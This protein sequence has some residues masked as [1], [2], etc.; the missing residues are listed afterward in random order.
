[1]HLA[2]CALCVLHLEDVHL[3]EGREAGVL[4]LEGVVLFEVIGYFGRSV[5]V[6]AFGMLTVLLDTGL[7]AILL[8]RV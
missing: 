4:F 6:L 5:A 7:A 3:V 1:V 8:H 2:E